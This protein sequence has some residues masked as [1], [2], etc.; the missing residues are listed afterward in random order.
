MEKNINKFNIIIP[1]K[2]LI[3][4][5]KEDGHLIIFLIRNR[6][7]ANRIINPMNQSAYANISIALPNK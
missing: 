3:K 5:K 1:T 4:N 2:S 6:I 7:G